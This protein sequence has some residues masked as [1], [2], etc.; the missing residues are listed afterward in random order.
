VV[1]E[2]QGES[3]RAPRAAISCHSMSG[4]SPLSVGIGGF[5]ATEDRAVAARIRSLR[6][7]AMTSGSWDRHRGHAESYDVIDIGFNYRLDEPRAALALSRL[8][9]AQLSSP[10]AGSPKP[11]T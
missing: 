10:G 5:V 1:V 6:S 2:D 11:V 8:A 3:L 7:H 9:R 4:S